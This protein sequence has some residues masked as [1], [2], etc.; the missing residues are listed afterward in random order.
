M[1]DQRRVTRYLGVKDLAAHFGLTESAVG[2]QYGLDPVG[3]FI[4]TTHQLLGH[5]KAAQLCRQPPAQDKTSCLLCRYEREHTEELRIAVLAA[6]A[7][8]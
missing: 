4:A 7:P 8:K 3:W 6:L 5:D 1:V 2:K